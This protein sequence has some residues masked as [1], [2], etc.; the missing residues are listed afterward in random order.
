MS[1]VSCRPL[2]LVLVPFGL[3]WGPTHSSPPHTHSTH[4]EY[5]R[6]RW[7]LRSF[8][9][10]GSPTILRRQLRV[11]GILTLYTM[12][13]KPKTLVFPCILFLSF[14]LSLSLSLSLYLYIYWERE[15][16]RGGFEI[17]QE[18]RLVVSGHY[19]EAVQDQDFRRCQR[20]GKYPRLLSMQL[21]S[22]IFLV[23][24]DGHFIIPVILSAVL[25][26]GGSKAG[27]EPK[28]SQNS[29]VFPKA[30]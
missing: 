20:D 14:S 22:P 6:Y 27:R 9:H 18:N 28:I 17:F 15:R 5:E 1:W 24:F 25:K 12:P 13:R 30:P 7:F 21:I 2:F 4:C 8:L 19:M 23:F 10:V 26:R 11:E 3:G 29:L 16:E